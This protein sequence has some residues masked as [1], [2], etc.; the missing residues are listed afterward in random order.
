MIYVTKIHSLNFSHNEKF[1]KM[2]ISNTFPTEF[3]LLRSNILY[4]LIIP[5]SFVIFVMWFLPSWMVSVID[6]KRGLINFNTTILACIQLG[7]LLV[8]RICLY[9]SWEKLGMNTVKYIVWCFAESV[10]MSLFMALYLTLKNGGT[11]F[12]SMVGQSSVIGFTIWIF[13]YTILTL[14]IALHDALS[15]KEN[16]ENLIRFTDSTKRLKLMIAA[17]AIL[18]VEANENYVHIFYLDGNRLKKYVLRSSLR[19]L[20][21]ILQRNGLVRCHRSYFIN[22]KRVKMLSKNNEGSYCAEF[23]IAD[24]PTIPVSAR[25]YDA[26]TSS[27]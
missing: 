19:S 10:L 22:P 27:L 13:P 11:S 26:V 4:L 20:E 6:M 15:A 2:K 14:S 7:V 18:Y 16:T 25:Y 1:I 24:T 3:S 21:D 12:F 8:T 5:I 23:D 17:A 9:V